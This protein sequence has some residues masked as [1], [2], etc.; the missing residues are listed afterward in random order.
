VEEYNVAVGLLK[1]AQKDWFEAIFRPQDYSVASYDMT[2]PKAPLY[3][4]TYTGLR[5]VQYTNPSDSTVSSTRFH[6]NGEQG[7]WGAYTMGLL[8]L[9]ASMGKSYGL[10]GSGT[11]TA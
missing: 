9:S 5:T 11:K 7:G 8:T 6:V 2:K 10:F 4:P 1:A 3:P